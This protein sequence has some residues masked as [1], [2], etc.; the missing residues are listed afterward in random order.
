LTEAERIRH[1]VNRLT[2]GPNAQTLAEATAD[3]ADGFITRQLDPASLDDRY[4]NAKLEGFQTLGM[5]AAELENWREGLIIQ[6]EVDPMV[7]VNELR[8]AT[9]LR[10]VYSR[11]QLYELMVDFWSNHFS[12]F[13]AKQTQLEFE[14]PVD[15]REV[16]RPHAVGR[17][18]DLLAASAHSPAMLRFLD[19]DQNAS[20]FPNENY[21]RELLEL[22]TVGTGAFTEADM[23][24]CTLVFTGWGIDPNHLFQ[25]A[26]ERHATGALTVLGWSTPGSAGPGAQ[27]DGESLL[28]YL[29]NHPATATHLARKLCRRFVADDPPEKLVASTAAVYLANQTAMVPVLEHIFASE[30]FWYS[31]GTKLRRPFEYLAA[32]LRAAAADLNVDLATQDGQ[33]A[34]VYTDY[35]LTTTGQ[36]LFGCAQPNGHP[37]RAEAWATSGGLIARW[38]HALE[39]ALGVHPGLNVDPARLIGDPAPPTC[40]SLVDA[41]LTRVAGGPT[42]GERRAALLS[43]IGDDPSA[44]P[45]T[46]SRTLGQLVGMA[47]AAAELQFR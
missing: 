39:L 20:T 46:D 30:D 19:N 6:H 25:F 41:L 44:P 9:V 21:G 11:R 3:G 27:G 1:V 13:T 23:R 31:A 36:Q 32:T 35:W 22:H 43:A 33:S 7:A 14:K 34:K 4:M 8:Y 17:F 16:I 26:P 28:V 24:A 5:S 15:D 10:A 2:F 42:P 29:A 37:D 38:N 40:G 47:L 45:P 12:I 18:A